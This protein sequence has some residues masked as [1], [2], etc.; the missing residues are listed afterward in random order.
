MVQ[1]RSRHLLIAAFVLVTSC[2]VWAQADDVV[3][4]VVTG[5][6]FIAPVADAA[7]V[8]VLAAEEASVPVVPKG[9]LKH[10]CL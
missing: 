2:C 3:A 6:E 10:M 1:Q 8:A 4:A 9:E 5:A 7:D